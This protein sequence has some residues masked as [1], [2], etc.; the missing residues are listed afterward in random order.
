MFSVKTEFSRNFAT[1]QHGCLGLPVGSLK[2][3]IIG[4]SWIDR[5]LR[6]FEIGIEGIWETSSIWIFLSNYRLNSAVKLKGSHSSDPP[7][8]EQIPNIHRYLRLM[9]QQSRRFL[10]AGRK[11]SRFIGS[12]S[13]FSI[14]SHYLRSDPRNYRTLFVSTRSRRD[15]EAAIR[16]F[17]IDRDREDSLPP[18]RDGALSHLLFYARSTGTW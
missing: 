16:P 15:V 7:S 10:A 13:E 9:K 11:I 1:L 14:T 4:F 2:K 3:Y 8:A 5:G 12:R 17:A 6:S 18:A